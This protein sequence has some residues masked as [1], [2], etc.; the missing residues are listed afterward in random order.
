MAA[1]RRCAAYNPCVF[2]VFK[3]EEI[4]LTCLRP[5][6]HPSDEELAESLQRITRLLDDERRAGRKIAMIVDMRKAGALSAN[7]RRISSGWMKEN[8]RGWK[9]VS[10]GSVFIINSPIVRGVLTALLW[11]QPLDMPHDVV[12]TLDEAVRWAIDRLEA[13]RIP[14]PER[15]RRELGAIFAER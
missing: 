12:G 9:Q 11:L 15:Y 14:V 10:V 6:G 5:S 8:L 13:E 7:Q 2:E 1:L 3:L 4:P